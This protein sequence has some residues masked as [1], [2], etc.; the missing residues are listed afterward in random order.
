MIIQES[1][2]MYLETILI[3]QNKSAFVRSVDL[4]NELGY[5]KASISRAMSKLKDAGYIKIEVSGNISLTEK[6]LKK[7]CEILERHKIITK[8]LVKTLDVDQKLADKDACRIEHIISQEIFEK[9]K[10]FVDQH[11]N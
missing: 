3:L 9:M 6:G 10:T 2:E 4:A 5:T 11:C 7:A 8:F 1:G